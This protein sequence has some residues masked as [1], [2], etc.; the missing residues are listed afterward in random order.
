MA[1]ILVVD[2]HAAIR[3]ACEMLLESCGHRAATAC[4]GLDAI[5]KLQSGGFD[6]ALVDLNMPR[7]S[8][9]ELLLWIQ[10]VMPS[11]PVIVMSTCNESTERHLMALGAASFLRK[12]FRA[13]ELQSAVRNVIPPLAE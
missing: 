11:L 12:P 13:A 8:G 1:H 10:K 4:D 7:M 6:A 3:S 9:D 2:D 5:D